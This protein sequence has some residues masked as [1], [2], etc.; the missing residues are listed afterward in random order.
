[1]LLP[2]LGRTNGIR[3]IG[4]LNKSLQTI[5]AGYNLWNYLNVFWES[6][7]SIGLK[8]NKFWQIF[9]VLEIFFQ[10]LKLCNFFKKDIR[11]KFRKLI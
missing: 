11:I 2:L 7:F 6:K 8:P 5:Q 1:M 4:G 10:K 9:F 3:A